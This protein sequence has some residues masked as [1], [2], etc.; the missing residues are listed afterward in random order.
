MPLNPFNNPISL[1][2]RPSLQTWLIIVAPHLI[3]FFL[4]VNI[5]VF[6]L[7]AKCISAIIIIASFAYYFLYY[8]AL[9]LKKSVTSIKQDSVENWFIMLANNDNDEE[10]KSVSLLPSSFISRFIIILN[11]IDKKDTY[12]TVVIMPDSISS[13]NFKHLYIKLKS[14]YIE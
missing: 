7:W 8:L 6:P 1:T 3:A 2:I 4:I 13:I 14:T 12:Y 10:L 9:K 11:F 5:E